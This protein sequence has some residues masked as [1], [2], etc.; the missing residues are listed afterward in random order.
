M[1]CYIIS[2][3]LSLFTEIYGTPPPHILLVG[4]G[5]PL[6]LHH[7]TDVVHPVHGAYKPV[8]SGT[9]LPQLEMGPWLPV[10]PWSLLV[11]VVSPNPWLDAVSALY[12]YIRP[13]VWFH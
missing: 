2:D 7:T 10:A 8:Q 12:G 5:T 1:A 6:F 11:I 3:G 4:Q 9:V 13:R